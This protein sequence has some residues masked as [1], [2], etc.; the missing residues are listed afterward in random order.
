RFGR[1]RLRFMKPT[2]G[3]TLAQQCRCGEIMSGLCSPDDCRLFGSECQPET[4][5]GACM[6]SSEGTC[7]IW[8]QYGGHPDLR[9]RA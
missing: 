8:H 5:V 4:P 3:S 7:R 9:S 2:L 6:V 1:Q